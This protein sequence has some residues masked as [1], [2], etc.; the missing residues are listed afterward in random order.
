MR[1]R[2]RR[3]GIPSSR[4]RDRFRYPLPEVESDRDSLGD[5]SSGRWA[6]RTVAGIGVAA[7]PVWMHCW[8]R[9]AIARLRTATAHHRW[10]RR[11][12]RCRELAGAAHC[13][14][15]KPGE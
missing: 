14:L 11:R 1:A 15:L 6:N 12:L 8:M 7:V 3:R 2:S 9:M 13:L 4:N 10:S 5:T